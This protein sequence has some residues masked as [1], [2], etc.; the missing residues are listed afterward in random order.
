MRGRRAA[1]A[2]VAGLGVVIAI[3][4]PLE[5]SGT[6]VFKRY[7]NCDALHRDYP[8]GVAKNTASARRVAA[9]GLDYPAISA[10][11]YSDNSFSDRDKDG[12]A[13]EVG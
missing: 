11:V 8:A 7:A 1:V 10:S 12:V 13:C 4:I 9:Q 3:A 2:A 6:V 5:A